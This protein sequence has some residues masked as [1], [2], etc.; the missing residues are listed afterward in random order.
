MS[1]EHSVPKRNEKSGRLAL[2]VWIALTLLSCV[3]IFAGV[4]AYLNRDLLDERSLEVGLPAS[5]AEVVAARIAGR[6]AEEIDFLRL[7]AAEGDLRLALEGRNQ[8]YRGTD[9]VVRGI[10]ADVDA[11]WRSAFASATA[12]PRPIA[13][14]EGARALRRYSRLRPAI[15]VSLI[16]DQYGAATASTEVLGQYDF[17]SEG[18][19]RNTL[20][21]G[22]SAVVPSAEADLA[23]V[24]P[25]PGNAPTP[26][27]VFWAELDSSTLVADAAAELTPLALSVAV[28]GRSGRLL[29]PIS[30]SSSV[31][32]D[33]VLLEAAGRG[34]SEPVRLDT[35]MGAVVAATAPIP[36]EGF[37]DVGSDLGWTVLVWRPADDL[38]GA[39]G[40]WLAARLRG[41]WIALGLAGL[42]AL[43]VA[44]TLSR[45]LDRV[46]RVAE[47]A[48]AGAEVRL[49]SRTGVPGVRSDGLASLAE[50]ARRGQELE[51][52]GSQVRRGLAEALERIGATGT[53][54]STASNLELLDR[55]RQQLKRRDLILEQIV[56]EANRLTEFSTPEP[57]RRVAKLL[58]EQES[59]LEELSA[60]CRRLAAGRAAV[61]AALRAELEALTGSRSAGAS[62]AGREEE[63]TSLSAGI[64]R[65]ADLSDRIGVLALNASIKAALVGSGSAELGEIVGEIEDLG[66]HARERL[67]ESAEIIERWSQEVPLGASALQGFDVLRN[68][69]EQEQ[70]LEEE[71]E[72]PINATAA[73]LAAL[74][75]AAEECERLQRQ[76]GDHL[77]IEADVAARIHELIDEM[78]T[79]TAMS[80]SL[81]EPAEQR[82]AEHEAD[83]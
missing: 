66:R 43:F 18:W 45:P 33:S 3:A 40:A 15:G 19:F 75:E 76:S 68:V 13:D 57:L 10:I 26:R 21:T 35:T 20:A 50:L 6:L 37:V 38:E 69:L 22:Q 51:T 67:A 12:P 17:S 56:A 1:D 53:S 59:R 78:A 28:V 25:M 16:V 27:G 2:A 54:L 60:F 46:R 64:S 47:A 31:L 14:N 55:L 44:A 39:R 24:L 49:P 52:E 11:Q 5:S 81:A 62:H 65:A 30:G 4:L 58:S 80:T 41:L 61:P 34:L 70:S 79:G 9:E 72:V 48:E 36:D 63:M 7:A 83:D 42:F 71:V 82:T 23:L 32:P 77:W 74:A 29:F 73:A 8:L